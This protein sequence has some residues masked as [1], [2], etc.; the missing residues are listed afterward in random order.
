MC[1]FFFA[2]GY[3]FL[4]VDFGSSPSEAVLKFYPAVAKRSNVLIVCL[5]FMVI[6]SS[7][8]VE[9]LMEVSDMSEDSTHITVGDDRSFHNVN[10]RQQLDTGE[11]SIT[12]MRGRQY[13]IFTAKKIKANRI[14]DEV[15]IHGI[16]HED[17][18]C[19]NDANCELQHY[20]AC[21]SND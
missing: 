11:Q 12:V 9:L 5:R 18:W 13:V 16:L 2:D 19:G 1:L 4:R 10:R 14:Q 8:A 3:G 17:G 21:T 7:P 20:N 6:L 15:Y